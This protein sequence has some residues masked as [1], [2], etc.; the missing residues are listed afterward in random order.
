[1]SA[2]I[3]YLFGAASF[4]PH[5]YCL[6]WRPDLV[7]L[8][9]VSDLLIALAYFSIPVGLWYFARQRPDFEYRGLFVLFAVFI[10]LCGLTH[11]IGLIT[12]WEPIYGLQGL[13]KAATAI[14]SLIAAY[15][16]WPVIPRALAIPGL[17][18]LRD[19][20]QEVGRA[21]VERDA[22]LSGLTA[23]NRDLEDFANTVAHDL[24][25]PLRS[26]NGFSQILAD[27]YGGQLDSRGHEMLDRVRLASLHMSRL[28]DDLLFL[29]QIRHVQ[30]RKTDVNLS[31]LATS[32]LG[33]FADR[34]PGRVVKTVIEDGVVAECDRE[35]TQI[36]LKQLLENAWKFT[37]KRDDS[38]IEFGSPDAGRETPLFRSRQ[39]RRLRHDPRQ[40]AFPSL[41][42]AARRRRVSRK[43]HRPGHRQAGR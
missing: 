6:L 2:I 33:E 8:H 24:R 39:R 31:Q 27:E 38:Q 12:L 32:I 40:Q 7:A 26:I 23:A 19:A 22:L 28:I 21:I 36:A 20:N 43:R 11:L 15:A 41:P 9:A 10:Q 35:L 30:I 1:M 5:G 25:S 42:P 16:L 34:E 13:V 4:M 18:G 14:V 29:S 37:A 3:D 17:S